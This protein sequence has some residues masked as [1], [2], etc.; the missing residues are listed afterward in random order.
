MVEGARARAALGAPRT[1]QAPRLNGQPGGATIVHDVNGDIGP[2]NVPPV[3]VA[4]ADKN[5]NVN[6]MKIIQRAKERPFPLVTLNTAMFNQVRQ[7]K[8]GGVWIT[9][10]IVTP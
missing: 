6:D 4:N 3:V 8:F 1:D 5:F 9:V 7:P 10:V 2:A